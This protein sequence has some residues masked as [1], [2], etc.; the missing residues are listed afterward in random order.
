MK[1]WRTDIAL[2][3]GKEYRAR[4]D[5][6]TQTDVFTKGEILIFTGNDYSHYHGSTA[7]RFINKATGEDKSWFLH[8]NEP[9]NSAEFFKPVVTP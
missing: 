8:D 6:K 4:K 9:D 1:T 5:F 2:V 3:E 7:L